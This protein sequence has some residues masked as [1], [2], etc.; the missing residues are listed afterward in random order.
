VI[1]A[2]YKHVPMMEDSPAI[3]IQNNVHGT[4]IIADFV[5]KYGTDKFVMISTDKSVTPTS[6]VGFDG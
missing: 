2:A 6:A 3:A 5:V 4:R 1:H